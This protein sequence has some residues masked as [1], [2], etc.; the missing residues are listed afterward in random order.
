MVETIAA[1][2]REEFP[3]IT[4]FSTRNLW[5]MRDFYL[6]Y[7]SNEKLSPLVTE[8]GWSHNLVILTKVQRRFGAR[9]LYSDDSK[10][11][12]D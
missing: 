7:A 1:D 3:K 11:W 9:I 5:R 4:G 8:I 10:I 2:V 6:T 12:L